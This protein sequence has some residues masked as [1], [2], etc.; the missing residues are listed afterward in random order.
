[1]LGTD[2]VYLSDSIL[3]KGNNPETEPDESVRV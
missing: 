3:R 2:T 1:V